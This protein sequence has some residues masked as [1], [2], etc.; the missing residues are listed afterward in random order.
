M[1][2]DKAIPAVAYVRKSTTE[3]GYEKSMADQRAR[4]AELR[5]AE[6]GCRYEIVRWYAKDAGVSGWKRGRKRPDYHQLVTDLR[7]RRDAKAV[8]IDEWDR[9]SRAD[10]LETVHD[11]QQLRELGV[12]Y[13][14]AASEGPRDLE[15]PGAVHIIGAQANASHAF[16][17]RLGRRTIHASMDKAAKGERPQG[18]VPYAMQPHGALLKPGDPARVKTVRWLFD[19]FGNHRRSLNSLA[20][21][22]NDRKEP[23]PT[24]GR[25]QVRTLRLLLSRDCYRG[26]MVWG[27]QHVGRFW[28]IDGQGRVVESRELNGEPGKVFRAEKAWKPVVDPALFDKVQRR[29]ASRAKE[30]KGRKDVGYALTR[31]L[32]CDHCGSSMYGVKMHGNTIYRCSDTRVHGKGGCPQHQV[33]EDIILPWL[34]KMLGEEIAGFAE[35]R[36]DLRA[37]LAGPKDF[38]GPDHLINPRGRQADDRKRDEAERAALAKK[39]DKAMRAR[40]ESDDKRTRQEYDVMITAMRDELDKMEAALNAPPEPEGLTLAELTALLVWWKEFEAK[41]VQVPKHD[42]DGCPMHADPREVNSA[43][44]ELGANV[45]L[46]WETREIATAGGSVRRRHVLDRLHYRLGQQKGKLAGYVLEPINSSNPARGD[47]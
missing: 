46:R 24:G 27:K 7:E 14:H 25:W 10:E 33:R 19:Q 6:P 17:K 45:R 40:I 26:D 43:F 23:G 4:I 47:A 36:S 12:R 20:G 9:F 30:R 22:L 42:G 13:I 31:V 11:V 35:L 5:P 37:K 8:L 34:V 38:Y 28:G 16:S 41:A 44:L 3:E 18:R 21:E 39:I 2:K 29:L 1:S 15:Q 32:V